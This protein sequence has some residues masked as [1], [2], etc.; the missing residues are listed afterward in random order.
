V[1]LCL[2]LIRKLNV[3]INEV[4]CSNGFTLFHFACISGSYEL[5]VALLPTANLAINT[6]NG[7]SPLFLAAC[8]ASWFETHLGCGPGYGILSVSWLINYTCILSILCKKIAYVYIN[9]F[10]V[11][12]IKY[13]KCSKIPVF[14]HNQSAREFF[15]KSV[16]SWLFLIIPQKMHSAQISEFI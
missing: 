1:G 10:P 6:Y 4:I 3:D 8:A 2:N 15:L 9:A 5:L 12:Y 16:I 14:I 13:C 11:R 7:D